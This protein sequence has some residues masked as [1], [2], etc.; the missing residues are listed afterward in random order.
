[1]AAG[2]V[3]LSHTLKTLNCLLVKQYP[4]NYKQETAKGKINSL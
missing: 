1:M 2:L 3:S 4:I